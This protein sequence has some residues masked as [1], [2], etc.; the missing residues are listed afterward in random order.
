MVQS[1]LEG[2]STKKKI[3]HYLLGALAIALSVLY[4]AFFSPTH[5]LGR[6]WLP[7]PNVTFNIAFIP[8]LFLAGLFGYVHSMILT[9][10]LLFIFLF[11]DISTA[12]F[13]ILYVLLAGVIHFA[14][15]KLWFNYK[16]KVFLLTLICSVII[17]NGEYFLVCVS[18]PD[19]LSYMTWFGQFAFFLSAVPECVLAFAI[20]HQFFRYAPDSIKEN[21]YCGFFYTWYYQRYILL[22]QKHHGVNALSVHVSVGLFLLLI[23]TMS[24]TILL[25][26]TL[27]NNFFIQDIPN[28]SASARDNGGTVLFTDL[29][30]MTL[31]EEH[32][33]VTP[34][35]SSNISEIEMPDGA[36]GLVMHS[37][38]GQLTLMLMSAII[39]AVAL[40]NFL[41][42]KLAVEPI[43]ELS[44]Y[45]DGYVNTADEERSHYVKITQSRVPPFDNEI[46]DAYKALRIL[47]HDVDEYVS[48]IQESQNLEDN[49]KIAQ[50]ANQAKSRFLSNVSHEIRTPINAV[51]GMDEMI[52]RESREPGTIEYA[53]DI[54]SAGKLLLG[55]INDLLDFSKIEA[56]QME[57]IPVEYDLTSII[58]DLY[59]MVMYRAKEKDLKLIFDYDEQMPHLL[60]GDEVRIRQCVLNILNNAVKYTE[61]GSIT[62]QISY[63]YA[64]QDDAYIN[65]RVTDTG[66]GIRK[67]EMDKLFT[68]FQRIDE[69]RNLTIEGTGLG[70]SIVQNLL[71]AMGSELEVESTYGKGSTFSFRILQRVVNWEPIGNFSK[72]YREMN[73]TSEKLY[74]NFHAPNA[75]VLVVDDTQ[76]NLSVV[77][78]LLKATQVHVDTALSGEI[79]LELLAENTYDMALIDY[80]MP[81]MDGVELLKYIRDLEDNPNQ[82]IPCIVLTANAISGAREEFLHYG[83]DDYLAKPVNGQLLEQVVMQYLPQE[84]LVFEGMADYEEKTSDPNSLEVEIKIREA[85]KNAKMINVDKALEFCDNAIILRDAL[86][87]FYLGIDAKSH[88]I[89]KFAIEKDFRNY[90]ILVH[91]LK[92]SARLIGAAQLSTYAAYLEECG[93]NEREDKIREL[94]PELL[95]QYRSIGSIL[96]N[97]FRREED[98]LPEISEAEL[99][100]AWEDLKELLEVYDYNNA[101]RIME[102]LKGYRLPESQKEKFDKVREL[103]AAV[104][105]EQLLMLL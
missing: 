7:L 8:V 53:K 19:G 54:Q 58:N 11:Q 78:G 95:R 101:D 97:L 29:H 82:H 33:V 100:Q 68:P 65:I 3:I 99:N 104:D 55:L 31:V 22:K 93:D 32:T 2:F 91:A 36:D 88:D 72:F 43:R 63:D 23:W 84:K 98:D 59:N 12:Y 70:M 4:C 102:M 45:I 16:K 73:E 60:I 105:R 38:F 89:E 48:K 20:L 92:S 28:D 27:M 90:T 96:A 94:T 13:A 81:K 41:A 42:Q 18:F 14:V 10:S 75:K 64:S 86:E 39:P 35:G 40:A 51:L 6:Q 74:E 66:M 24:L 46:R 26:Y 71:H 67:E 34:W 52:L 1:Y 30:F 85:L 57:I 21:F 47:L 9:L 49:L 17:G 5:M 61:K 80:R 87:E 69:K 50:A 77:K 15:K 83:F 79:A 25:T 62:F 44:E 37:F 103:M 56:G 76:M